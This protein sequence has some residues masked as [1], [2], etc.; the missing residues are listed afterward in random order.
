MLVINK[1]SCLASV[2]D[3]FLH[4]KEALTKRTGGVSLKTMSGRLEAIT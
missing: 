3:K 4:L 1:F 2:I